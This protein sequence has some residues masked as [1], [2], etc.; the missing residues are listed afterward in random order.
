MSNIQSTPLRDGQRVEV[1]RKPSALFRRGTIVR[2][3]TGFERFVGLALLLGSGVGNY[4]AFNEGAF[5]PFDATAFIAALAGLALLT[6]LQWFYRP[7]VPADVWWFQKIVYWTMGLNWKYCASVIVGVG[8]TVYGTRTIA[9]PIFQNILAPWLAPDMLVVAS[10][11]LLIVV[12]LIVE[13]IPE[14]ILVD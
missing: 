6:A 4:L 9:L 10:W 1:G 5:Q 14:N 8:L 11:G 13:V 3:R 2:A 12:S 7:A